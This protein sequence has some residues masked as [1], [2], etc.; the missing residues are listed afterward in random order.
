MIMQKKYPHRYQYPSPA[1]AVSMKRMALLFIH[2]N[3]EPSEEELD[4]Y[5]KQLW[6]GDEFADEV[7]DWYRQAGM[8]EARQQLESI[9][10]NPT[11]IKTAPP[12]VQ[13]FLTCQLKQPTWLDETKLELGAAT[14][15]RIGMFGNLVMRDMALM[16]GYQSSAINKPLI[17]TGALDSGADRRLAE[18]R[19]F[20]IDVTRPGALRT[21]NPGFKTSTHV[22][23][24]HSLIR[25]MIMKKP[26]WSNEDWGLPINQ[27]DMVITNLSFSIVFLLGL[28]SLGFHFSKAE[29]EAVL[30]LWRYVGH[31]L[32]ID[33]DLL[34]ET[35]QQGRRLLYL[36][37]RTQPGSDDDSRQ[38]AAA[39][40]DQPLQQNEWRWLGLLKVQMHS[41]FSRFF[42]DKQAVDDLR[43]AN[44]I[45]RIWPAFII[46]VIFMVERLR[47]VIP[48]ATK[49]A[50]KVGGRWQSS[51]VDKHLAGK[52]AEFKVEG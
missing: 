9:L 42:L 5:G 30:H 46:P 3:P 21:E 10:E 49:L 43:L 27:A 19:K 23:I 35:E 18:T 7:A 13:H 38:L 51:G 47:V 41:G 24:M 25:R 22:R 28:R 50:V 31:L 48:G 44:N 52:Q 26:G 39:L 34:P 2:G 14:C 29:A 33:A 4:A 32:G 20:W 11:E 40:R 36:A 12:V 45:W 8:A 1:N 16:G 15:R 17:F 6:L 37:T